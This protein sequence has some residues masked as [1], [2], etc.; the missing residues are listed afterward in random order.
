MLWA[1]KLAGTLKR[2]AVKRLLADS[3]VM[4]AQA[5]MLH[6]TTALEATC[7]PQ[8]VCYDDFAGCGKRTSFQRFSWSCWHSYLPCEQHA[9]V[10]GVSL[11]IASHDHDVTGHSTSG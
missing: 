1:D 9:P 10:S 7:L 4:T 11:N 5:S 3:S 6:C 8:A 2:T